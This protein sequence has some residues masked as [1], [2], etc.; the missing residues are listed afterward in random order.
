MFTHVKPVSTHCQARFAKWNAVDTLWTRTSYDPSGTAR[1]D[2]TA[3]PSKTNIRAYKF[4]AKGVSSNRKQRKQR[5]STLDFY[6]GKAFH[7]KTQMHMY[8]NYHA[9]L[10]ARFLATA[11]RNSAESRRSEFHL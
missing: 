1:R 8:S 10:L 2:T 4:I 9:V 7:F 5:K 3:R 6:N 11:F